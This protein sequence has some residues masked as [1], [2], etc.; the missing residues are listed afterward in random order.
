MLVAT[1]LS[2][3]QRGYCRVV[4]LGLGC[5]LQNL[6]A[7][8]QT[9]PLAQLVQLSRGS[10]TVESVLDE[11]KA[12]TNLRFSYSAN[13]IA[14]RQPVRVSTAPQTV[15][16]VLDGLAQAAG[17]AYLL[18]GNQLI[19]RKAASH[20]PAHTISGYVREQGS[21][22]LLIGAYVYVAG[23]PTGGIT[24]N[25]GFYSLT[26]SAAD[27]VDL[28][29][30]HL[31]YQ[32]ITQRLSLRKDAEFN[33]EM[34]P[35]ITILPE[36]T[37][38]ARSSE[39]PSQTPRMSTVDVPIQQMLQVPALLGEKD[40]MKVFQLLPGVQKGRE[41]ASNLYVR[42]GGPD[43]NLVILD[44]AVVY[45][46]SHGFGFLSLFNGDAL[47]SV[48][49]TKG[50]FPAR[51]GGRLSSV[52]EM[53]MKE[54]N[55]EKLRG[56]G[57]IGLVSSRL[58]LEGPLRW[59]K[60]SFL[61]SGRRSYA[62]LFIRPLAKVGYTLYDLNAKVNYEFG[63]KNKL[64]LSG[65]FGRDR[66]LNRQ[67]GR[68]NQNRFQWGNV[69]GTM[70]WNH[71][72]NEKL[73]ANA[74][75]VFSHYQFEL[76]SARQLPNQPPYQFQYTSRI[77]D[78]GI[79]Y[80]LD[81]FPAPRHAVKAGFLGT[82]HR[83]RPQA[84]VTKSTGPDPHERNV[85]T[86]EGIES[87]AY[88]Q[89]TYQPWDQLSLNA[90]IRLSHF[91]TRRRQYWNAEP[92]LSVAYHPRDEL[93]IKASYARM[94]QY[95]HLISNTGVGLP[96]DQ[97]VLA[98]DQ[99]APQQAWQTAVGI[100]KDW[101]ERGLAFTA[102]TYYKQ[103]ANVLNYR[104]GAT[105]L[106]LDQPEQ[107]EGVGSV[108]W[109]DNVTAGRGWSYGAE[110]L[111]QKQTGRLSGWVGYTLSWSRQQFDAL[112]GG[113]PFYASSDRRHDFSVTASYPLKKRITLAGSWVF[114]SG[115]PV[116]VPLA[117]YQTIDPQ[118]IIRGD[119][120]DGIA[121]TSGY[122]ADYGER[123]AVRTPV[124]HRLDASV[125]F[126]KKKRWGERTWE[127]NVYN[128]YNRLNP[129]LYF[130]DYETRSAG[131]ASTTVL[132]KGGIGQLALFPVIPS[133]SYNFKF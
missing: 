110:L 19:L 11:L 116:T 117:V 70:R 104:D 74:S 36:A 59:G 63:R 122:A 71:Q 69:T 8:A 7:P 72:F 65:Y 111:L 82:Y 23:R 56:Q 42:G 92:R 49:L 20:L 12:Q 81:Y 67:N 68:Q 84:S 15:R 30:S 109:E 79:K 120:S 107:P 95:V 51:F 89:D 54:G 24:N 98:T 75:L 4:L 61:V 46:T 113:K 2:P 43:Q 29:V 86:L 103:S 39:K 94:N 112:N 35:R 41:G 87:G 76:S 1:R 28:V 32:P 90:G 52:V 34:T 22:E 78:W 60:S 126:H 10:G 93:A 88:L 38:N 17:F 26:L 129:F 99:L 25:Y 115:S 33:V 18:R 45:N 119:R 127:I 64:Y 40:V 114:G 106:F 31:V 83:F 37:V 14:L 13:Q 58:T 48:A 16:A 102:E 66:L 47:K 101:T 123:D 55:R 130:S 3:S 132:S 5:L 125:Q 44:D 57:G 9:S 73:F 91:R 53:S 105:F 80:D 96:T 6:A 121:Y 124:Y 118:S 62:D 21:R 27:S 128:L 131:A 77:R 100:A 133:V 85:A 97:W 50:G 108:N